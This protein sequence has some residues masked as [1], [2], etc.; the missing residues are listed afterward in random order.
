[1][2]EQRDP[3]ELSHKRIFISRV[4]TMLMC[5]FSTKKLFKGGKIKLSIN[6]I[7]KSHVPPSNED[8]PKKLRQP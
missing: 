7:A 3:R 6:K 2:P 5:S 1:M 4:G 8:G